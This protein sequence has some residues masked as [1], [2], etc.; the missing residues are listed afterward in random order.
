[1]IIR[2]V[3]H[4]EDEEKNLIAL[5]DEIEL[6]NI[7]IQGEGRQ[8]RLL[9]AKNVSEAEQKLSEARIDCALL[10]L[11]LPS[12]EGGPVSEGHGN[13]LVRTM[14][15]SQGMPIA[16]LSGHTG[17]F[18]EELQRNEMVRIF[19]KGAMDGFS[20]AVGWLE[21]CWSMM[22]ILH[23]ARRRIEMSTSEV[24]TKRIWPQWQSLVDLPGANEER[25]TSIIS[26]QFL[27]H[28]AELMGLESPDNEDWHPYE[29]YVMPALLDHRPHTGDVFN[30]DGSRWVV[31]TPQCDMAT[32]KA[33]S[34]L[35]AR[36][37]GEVGG[38]LEKVSV[39][40]D[41]ASPEGR[42]NKAKKH[43]RDLINQNISA[44]Q[45]FLPPIPGEGQPV[46]VNFGEL[47]TVA[48]EDL[49]AAL[50][51]RVASVSPPFLSNLTQRFGAFMSRAGQPNIN[52]EHF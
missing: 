44:S 2:T 39:I 36:C 19:D 35:L 33:T 8:F 46:M 18:D 21:S 22:Q 9:V 48:L 14:L 32:G 37:D 15:R 43:L 20:N 31:L 12:V 29:N 45:H 16:V 17:E 10:D 51:G 6:A 4:V 34:V 50:A 7:R 25:L 41:E 52:V 38:F 47:K 5:K 3:L 24:F 42:R 13:E 23:A 26:R 1:M 11:R 28:A 40:R 30:L 49:N 27:G